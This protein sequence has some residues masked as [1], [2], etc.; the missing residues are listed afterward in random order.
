MIDA[1]IVLA[2]ITN[3]AI[4][5]HA[6]SRLESSVH[7]SVAKILKNMPSATDMA[8]FVGPS[9][10][11]NRREMTS[12]KYKRLEVVLSLRMDSQDLSPP[13][14]LMPSR[15]ETSHQAADEIYL[16]LSMAMLGVCVQHLTQNP[17]SSV[18]YILQVIFNALRAL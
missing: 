15:K 7:T 13:Q 14:K 12:V 17:A 16:P 9:S 4:Y 11:S 3:C 5:V 1:M 10:L 18:P 6:K 2:F 8:H